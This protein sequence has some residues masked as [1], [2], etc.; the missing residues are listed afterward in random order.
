MQSVL[1]TCLTN[2]NN[3][4]QNQL[5][6]SIENTSTTSFAG[7]YF[8]YVY[9]IF[10]DLLNNVLNYQKKKGK[11]VDCNIK[12]YEE[13]ELLNIIISNWIDSDDKEMIQQKME[14]YKNID[15]LGSLERVAK[16]E[17]TGILKIYNVVANIL[18]CTGNSYVNQ[19]KEDC[20]CA[21]ITL[22]KKCLLY[23]SEG[24]NS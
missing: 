21:T 20:F 8:N 2:I 1:D 18:H 19:V 13:E 3:M 16:E 24:S 5:S 12:V 7:R 17:N 11:I 22:N 6:C 4:N 15:D 9:D 14:K 23:G 10:H